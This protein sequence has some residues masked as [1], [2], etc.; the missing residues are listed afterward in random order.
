MCFGPMDDEGGTVVEVVTVVDEVVVDE[1]FVELLV[2]PNN[3]PAAEAPPVVRK[4]A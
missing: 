1:M 3:S 4:A 2:L